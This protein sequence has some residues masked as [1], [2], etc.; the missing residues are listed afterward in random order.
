MESARRDFAEARVAD[1]T[2]VLPESLAPTGN[3]LRAE[4][5]ALPESVERTPFYAPTGV[6]LVDGATSTERPVDRPFVLQHLVD[7]RPDL[8]VRVDAGSAT[9]WSPPLA[10]PASRKSPWP[11]WVATGAG[12]VAGGA[13][14]WAAQD[15]HDNVYLQSETKEAADEQRDAVNALAGVS[16]GFAALGLGCGA[17]AAVGTF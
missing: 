3:P 1:P 9:P 4:W 6:T 16:V 10:E 12:A 7:E 13:F 15:T 17:V 2:Y 11:W 8:T 5:A 14:Y